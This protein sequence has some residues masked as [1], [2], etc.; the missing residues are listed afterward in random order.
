MAHLLRLGI[1]PTGYI[2]PKETRPLRDLLR[3]RS[4]LVQQR[5]SQILS[6]QNLY[7]RN[8][9]VSINGNAVKRL[10]LE[11]LEQRFSDPDLVLAMDSN[12][13]VMLALDEQIKRLEQRVVEQARLEPRYQY[14]LT[15]N[16][17]GKILA[18]TIMLETGDIGRFEHVGNFA[19]YCRCVDSQRLSN[20][21]QK[22]TGNTKNGNRYLAWAFVE[23]ANFAIRYHEPA[24]RY[25]QRKLAKTKRVVAIKALSHKLARAS[26]YVMR[27]Q[28]PFDPAKIYR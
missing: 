9:G 19:S 18:L 22:G 23:A 13:R 16:G 21:K 27:D 15:V 6:I 20:G 12:R 25:Y 11:Q 14:L 3:K 7:I 5:T 1:L 10:R 4:Q 26:Y 8:S 24:K 2:Y 28:V 17:I